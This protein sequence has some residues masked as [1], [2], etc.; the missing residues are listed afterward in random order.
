MAFELEEL[1]LAF[2][3][4]V[5]DL[6]VQDDAVTSDAEAAFLASVFPEAKL[7][8]RGFFDEGGRT[9][10]FQEAAVAALDVLPKVLSDAQKRALL[11]RCF[12]AATV[13]DD[14]RRGEAGVVLMASRLLGISDEIFETMLSAHRSTDSLSVELL[15]REEDATT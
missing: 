13:D 12:E 8:V 5:V 9:E 3:L 1:Q 11:E 2:Q 6:V 10:R 15:D 7:H 4:Y 14:L